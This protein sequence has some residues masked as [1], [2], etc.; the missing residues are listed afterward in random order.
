MDIEPET[1]WNWEI[2]QGTDGIFTDT[3]KELVEFLTSKGLH[4]NE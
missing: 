1:I 3:P 2:E 4:D